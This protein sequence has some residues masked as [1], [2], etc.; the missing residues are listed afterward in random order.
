MDRECKKQ[1]LTLRIK[2][3]LPVPAMKHKTT[4][5]PQL[6]GRGIVL[7]PL[8]PLLY[9]EADVIPQTHVLHRI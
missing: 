1:A 5:L 4:F 3:S 7:L 8:Q 6:K 9:A 2:F